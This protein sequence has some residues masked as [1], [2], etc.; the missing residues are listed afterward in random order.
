MIMAYNVGKLN[1]SGIFGTMAISV[2]V[3]IYQGGRGLCV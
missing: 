3:E 2:R 1:S